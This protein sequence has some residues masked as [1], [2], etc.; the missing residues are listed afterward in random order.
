MAEAARGGPTPPHG[1]IPDEILIWDILVRLPPKS[2]LRCR[3]VCRAWRTA[4][5]ARDFLIANHARQPTRPLLYVCNLPHYGHYKVGGDID[6]IPFDHRAAADKLQPVALLG[7]ASEFK[8]L[9]ASFD[10]LVVFDWWRRKSLGICNSATRQYARLMV[11]MDFTFLGM[12]R[13][14]PT[15]EYRVLMY[16][17]LAAGREA[18]CY[19]LSLG[20]IQPPR[21]IVRPGEVHKEV[22]FGTKSV[23]FRGGLHWYRV[24]Q[25]EGESNMIIVFDTTAETFRQM[26]VPVVRG[27][28]CDGLFE[29][30]GMLGMSSF[31]DKATSIDIWVLQDYASEVWTFKCHIELP[32]AEIMAS[33]G[34]RDDDD[35]WETVVVPGDGELL[36]LVK[37]PNWLVQIDMDGK[38]VATFNH[39]GVQPTQLQLK[40]SLVPHDFFPSLHGYVVNGWPFT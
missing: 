7:R 40:Q 6:I 30:D 24:Q 8:D 18:G 17:C 34:K 37:F 19:V 5:S 29:M 4:T 11:P 27:T 35:S 9:V 20:S 16:P 15:G 14:P 22:I 21:S 36:V 1:G 32:L 26:R 31:N 39:T 23:L 13:H 25:H 33:C 3:A 10:G 2:L 28:T 38:L 12:Y